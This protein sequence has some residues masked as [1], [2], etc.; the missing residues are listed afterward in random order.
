[1]PPTCYVCCSV[2]KPI[3]QKHGYSF[4]ACTACGLECISPQPD[5]IVLAS[6]YRESYYDAWGLKG[7]QASVKYL[8]QGSFSSYLRV[9]DEIPTGSRLL[10]CGAATGFLAELAKAKGLDAY[11]IELSSFGAESC[12]TL[13]GSDHVYE[14]EVEEAW[15]P[16]NP[17]NR[18]DIITM[19][20]FIE[21]VRRPRAALQ[22]ATARLK[23]TGS[24]L[25]V[26]PC[27]GSLLH[28]LMGQRW[29]HYKLEHLWYFTPRSLTALLIEVGF[30]IAALRPAYKKL[31]LDYAVH[32]FQTYPHPL[33]SRV[34][35]LLNRVLPHFVK[36]LNFSLPLGE[37]LVHA[38]LEGPR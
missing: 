10:D 19:I 37:M 14:G 9:L 12:R 33:I 30:S 38:F 16:A 8:K 35:L 22:W 1:M 15:F 29:T 5:D 34:L 13:L 6:I 3:F 26:T 28:R 17:E 2:L 7:S 27:V 24:L 32:Q 23:P 31:S 18:F 25:L 36:A 11:A 20:D 4:W 21:H